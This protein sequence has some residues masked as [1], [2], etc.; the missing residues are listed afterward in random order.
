MG[1]QTN[2]EKRNPLTG[3]LISMISIGV[4]EN[5]DKNQASSYNLICNFNSK[6]NSFLL[7]A[8]KYPSI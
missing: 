2:N 8:I 4:K 6:P 1:K 3:T 5:N 7:V